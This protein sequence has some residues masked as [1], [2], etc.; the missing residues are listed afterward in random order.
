M[1]RANVTIS[2]HGPAVDAGEI[3]IADLA[4][5]LLHFSEVFKE[6]HRVL[7][8]KT[9]HPQ[10]MVK[11]TAANCFSVDISIVQTLGE[12][13]AQ[14]GTWV[15]GHKDE[16]EGVDLLL[17]L[18]LKGGSILAGGA[19]VAVGLFALLKK[20]K[21]KDIVSLEGDEA[22]TTIVTS[23]NTE[24]TVD[25]RVVI[26]LRDEAVRVQARAFVDVLGKGGIERIVADDKEDDSV[27]VDI[28]YDEISAFD[29][30]DATDELVEEPLVIR[31]T[32][33]L[34]ILALS[35]KD[36][37]KWRFTAGDESFYATVEDVGFLNRIDLNQIAFSK[38]DFLVCD[39][40]ETQIVTGAGLKFERAIEKV[41][42]HIPGARQLRLI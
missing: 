22:R 1:S 36:D 35:F 4:P 20:L 40:R 21:D 3:D 32:L 33:T 16:L 41:V 5:A 39:V 24:I 17:E 9:P 12:Q 14:L 37:N 13:I 18:I 15:T 10:V 31:R 26:L 29:V 30:P 42:K 34:K 27:G 7:G 23:D 6:A 38:G 28:R 8:L 25:S 2:F 11:A 19:T